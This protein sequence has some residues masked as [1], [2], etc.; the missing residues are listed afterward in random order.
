MVKTI[1][2]GDYLWTS[3]SELVKLLGLKDTPNK[4]F[5]P[6]LIKAVIMGRRYFLALESRMERDCPN[7]E[8]EKHYQ[9]S[10]ERPHPVC[11]FYK[12]HPKEMYDKFWA[13][14]SY[15]IGSDR[16]LEMQKG[17]LVELKSALLSERK[18]KEWTEGIDYDYLVKSM[19]LFG[20]VEYRKENIDHVTLIY[21]QFIAKGDIYRML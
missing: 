4:F 15:T 17:A 6:T 12:T 16:F 1:S 2:Q 9:E 13:S 8:L 21:M 14:T 11:G 18:P 10:I 19:K 7:C 5:T 3:F 20:D